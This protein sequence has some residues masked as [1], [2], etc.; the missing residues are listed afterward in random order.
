MLDLNNYQLRFSELGIIALHQLERRDIRSVILILPY[1]IKHAGLLSLQ[2]ISI[3]HPL[4][5]GSFAWTR[6]DILL[7]AMYITK[8][9][10]ICFRISM[11]LHPSAMSIAHFHFNISYKKLIRFLFPLTTSLGEGLWVQLQ[12]YEGL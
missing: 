9:V 6:L 5:L 3:F 11:N 1:I 7:S 12:F 4:E 10:P 2:K 8:Y